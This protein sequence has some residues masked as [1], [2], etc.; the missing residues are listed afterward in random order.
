MAVVYTPFDRD[1]TSSASGLLLSLH[2]HTDASQVKFQFPPHVPDDGRKVEW[3]E[4]NLQGIEPVAEYKT[5]GPRAFSLVYT[6]IVDGGKWTIPVIQAQLRLIRGYPA[7]MRDQGNPDAMIVK[8]K[9]WEIGGQ[10]V[11]HARILNIS[12][13]HGDVLIAP[14]A[15]PRRPFPLKTDVTVDLR[16]WSK[17][18]TKPQQEVVGLNDIIPPDWY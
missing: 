11:V 18:G 6:Y 16:L 12:I 4:G 17:A 15:A 5:S 14:E 8:L 10:S 3:G 2:P 9:L 1:A 13:K 7:R